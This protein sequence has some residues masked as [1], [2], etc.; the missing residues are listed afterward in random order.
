MSTA[1]GGV[2]EGGGTKLGVPWDWTSQAA[3]CL[4][5]PPALEGGPPTPTPAVAQGAH[6]EARHRL[7]RGGQA[8]T[9]AGKPRPS[10]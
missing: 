7:G 8:R 10:L 5:F 4:P 9:E 6:R 3:Q 2:G 1:S